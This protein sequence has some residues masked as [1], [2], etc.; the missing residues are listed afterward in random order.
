MGQSLGAALIFLSDTS[1]EGF[2]VT[3]T[4]TMP[5]NMSLPDRGFRPE[6]RGKKALLMWLKGS[7]NRLYRSLPVEVRFPADIAT[8]PFVPRPDRM[9]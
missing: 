2:S 7:S 9:V 4:A 1:S 8:R 6:L 5:I 3:I